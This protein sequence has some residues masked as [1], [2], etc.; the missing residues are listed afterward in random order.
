MPKE[1]LGYVEM[2]WMCK[3]CGTKNPGAQKTCTN[4]GAAMSEGQQ[5]ELP[6]EQ[7]LITDKEKV[8]EMEKGAD[9]HCANCGTRNPAGSATCSQCGADLTKAT[10]RQQGAVVGA[11][12]A[13]PVA[14]VKC[15]R[16]G[17]RNAATAA[18]CSN[19]GNPLGQ[20]AA[21]P[22]QAAKP[23]A[24]TGKMGRILGISAGAVVCLILA[25]CVG[26]FFFASAKT[27]ATTGV[28]QAVKW[29]RTIEIQEQ[30][31]VQHQDW[32]DQVPQ[33][34]Q[35]GSC[36]RKLRRTQDQPAPDSEKVCGT[37]YTVDQGNGTGKVVQDCQYNVY[38]NYCEYTV[39]EWKVVDTARAQGADLN[40]EWPALNLRSGQREGNRNEKYEV[41]F[42]AD[43]KTYNYT[44]SDPGEFLQF[45]PGSK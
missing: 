31:P 22:P 25:I 15:P 4:C 17:T 39:K 3:Y 41:T 13:G 28:V 32:E 1:T 8:A 43:G 34:A 38:E 14:E 20:T 37:P 24:Q 12:Q 35:F 2:E 40:P 18:K 23:A 44:P 11:F 9:I 45:K 42:E 27:N 6:T 21:P 36:E 7:K 29:D 16:C 5:F 33:D 19:C 26:A 10:A 30:G